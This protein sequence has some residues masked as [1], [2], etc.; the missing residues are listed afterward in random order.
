MTR[1]LILTRHAKSAWDNPELADHDRP[2][3][4]RGR[5]SAEAIGD[6]LRQK[7]HVPDQVLC[8]SAK[9]TRETYKRMGFELA[10]EVTEHLYLVTANQILRVLSQASGDTVLLLGHNP[11]ISQ[12]AGAIVA[13]PPAHPKFGSYP[14][15][16]T[17]VVEFDIDSWDKLAW[18]GG[19]VLDFTVPR[20]LLGA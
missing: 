5:R 10:P 13:K 2:L 11:G 1:T 6:W 19:K 7:G 17:L 8:S 18:R 14:T 3:T 12:F 15:G 9:R 16:A 4:K 20:D